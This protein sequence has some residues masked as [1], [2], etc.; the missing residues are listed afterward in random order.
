MNN[1]TNNESSPHQSFSD[2]Q[3]AADIEQA[4]GV[5]QDI[6][7]AGKNRRNLFMQFGVH[8]SI[9]VAALTFWAAA[10][11]WRL[12][13]DL[14]FASGFSVLASVLFGIA[15]AHILHEWSHFLGAYF[16][17]ADYTVKEKPAPLFFD[18]DYKNNSKKQFLSMSIGGTVGNILFLMA[19][20]FAIPMDS[21]GRM[22]LLS[23]AIGMTFYVS[24]IEF[25]VIKLASGGMS[26][27]ES[28][29]AHLGQGQA[30]LNIA[31]LS[32]VVATMMSFLLIFL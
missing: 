3:A 21:I 29:L 14:A 12:V 8:G 19:I 2:E 16:S 30:I 15:M 1:K 5:K 18:F 9:F 11:A 13:S 31:L 22:M 10:D 23:V 28:L 4:F 27:M 32:G 7:L 26:A 25:P 20:Y 6:S 24:V 17:R